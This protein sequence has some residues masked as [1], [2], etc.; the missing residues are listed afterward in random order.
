MPYPELEQN[1]FVIKAYLHAKDSICV[2]IRNTIRFS[3]FAKRLFT[4][5]QDNFLNHPCPKVCHN[6]RIVVRQVTAR[7]VYP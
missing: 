4:V 6:P 5:S 7:I 3:C 1:L 2:E